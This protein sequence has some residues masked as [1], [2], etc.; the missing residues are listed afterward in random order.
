LD[1][2]DDTTE[3]P[4]TRPKRYASALRPAQRSRITNGKRLLPSVH[5]QSAWARIMRDTMD[6]MLSHLGGPDNVTEPQRMAIR[7][8]ALLE[9]EL[10][11]FEDTIGRER[12]EGRAPLPEVL[13]LYARLSNAQRRFCE[14]LGWQ[15]VP[16]DAT[17]DIRS[18]IEAAKTDAEGDAS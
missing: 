15:R 9:T 7:R 12:C 11:H 10:V 1:D 14:A 18:Y 17:M 4:R 5:R 13:D 8:I 3:G 16:R 2:I 6:A